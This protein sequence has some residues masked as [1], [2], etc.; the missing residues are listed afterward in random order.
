MNLQNEKQILIDNIST[1]EN[2]GLLEHTFSMLCMGWTIDDDYQDDYKGLL[3]LVIGRI[4]TLSIINGIEHPLSEMNIDEEEDKIKKL[5]M[6][7]MIKGMIEKETKPEPEFN[8][9]FNLN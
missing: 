3:K 6:L 5:M 2:V 8:F 1:T 7:S 4:K 9:D